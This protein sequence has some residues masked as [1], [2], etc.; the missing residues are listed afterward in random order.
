MLSYAINRELLAMEGASGKA[1]EDSVHNVGFDQVSDISKPTSLDS[2]PV[3]RELKVNESDQARPEFSK[4]SIEAAKIVVEK[5]PTEDDFEW[6]SVSKKKSNKKKGVAVIGDF[7]IEDSHPVITDVLD[8]WGFSAKSKSKKKGTKG[9]VIFDQPLVEDSKPEAS[10]VFDEWGFSP[11]RKSQKR[12][13]SKELW[14]LKTLQPRT[15]S[16]RCSMSLM[17]GD[18]T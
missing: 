10:G 17:S 9:A 1:R 11:K 8:E 16:K 18:S 6:G 14:T 2:E 15:P 4:D 5:L 7:M 12:K 3:H 13:E